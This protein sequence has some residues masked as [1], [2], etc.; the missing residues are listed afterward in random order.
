VFRSIPSDIATERMTIGSD[1]VQDEL[2]HIHSGH[3]C[4]IGMASSSASFDRW[5]VR[6]RW[7]CDIDMQFFDYATWISPPFQSHNNQVQLNERKRVGLCLSRREVWLCANHA[8]NPFYLGDP[9]D[10]TT[11][12]RHNSLTLVQL[13]RASL[14]DKEGWRVAESLPTC[15]F[16]LLI[17]VEFQRVWCR[18]VKLHSTSDHRNTAPHL[19]SIPSKWHLRGSG[20]RLLTPSNHCCY[21][22]RMQIS[23]KL[24]KIEFEAQRIVIARLVLNLY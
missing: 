2:R 7:V 4:L 24:I 8:T 16:I 17:H 23:I 21:I 19:E 14:G 3:Q 18:N 5:H 12:K 13:L 11:H 9:L 20:S 15:N 10:T 1:L 22:G 6:W